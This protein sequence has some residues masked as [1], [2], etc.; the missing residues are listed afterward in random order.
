MRKIAIIFPM[1]LVVS[2]YAQSAVSDIRAYDE[3]VTSKFVT[4]KGYLKTHFLDNKLYLEIP[5]KM[6]DKDMLFVEHHKSSIPQQVKWLKKGNEIR[7]V[8]PEIKS[9]S[10]NTIPLIKSK[11]VRTD[12]YSSYKY[13]DILN[14]KIVPD[15]FPIL[16]MGEEDSSYVIDVTRLF[17]NTPGSLSRR[18]KA[19][20]NGLAFIDKVFAFDNAI[21]V[22]TNKIFAS[23]NGPLEENIDFSL[24]LLPEPMMPRLFDHR[25]G[26]FTETTDL[27]QE[28]V[29]ASIQRWRLEKKHKNKKLSEPVKPIVFYFDPAT[30]DKWKPYIKAGVE[31]WLPAF[32][33]A[34]F[35]GA[36]LI[37]E[38][39][40]N[41][42][43]WSINS[44]RYSYIRWINRSEYREY[45]G[46]GAGSASKVVDQRT[47]E[48]LKGDI[49][50]GRTNTLVNRYFTRCAPLDKRAQQYPFPD[51]LM[52]ELIQSLT[53]HE[54]GHVFGL[55]DGN[56]GIFTYP[57]GK[58]RDKKWLQKM[59]HT[60]SIMSY[61][62][63][64]FVVQPE[65]NI[66]PSLLIQKLGP[67][68]IYSIRW[69]YTQF[70][71]INTPDD[72]LSYL[73]KIVREQDSTPWYKYT[74]HRGTGM[75]GP[76][77]AMEVVGCDNPVKAAELGVKNLQRVIKLIPQA[78]KNQR[79][80]ELLERFYQKTL[81]L[82]V[83][84][85][86]SVVFLVG[87][88]TTRYK[89]AGQEGSIH[90]F[91]AISPSLQKEAIQFLI[92][93][94]F[95]TPS[96]MNSQDISR[97]QEVPPYSFGSI[98]KISNRQIIVLEALLERFRL[99]EE[100]DLLDNRKRYKSADI[101]ND[102]QDGIWSE[103][104]AKKIKIDP[105]RQQV[106]VAYIKRLINC[107]EFDSK[108]IRYRFNN[109][110]RGNILN[111]LKKVEVSIGK[112]LHKVDDASTKA[113]LELCLLELK[114]I[115]I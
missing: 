35:K 41:D 68:D 96:W 10:G 111:A 90:D 79:G 40:V 28:M 46:V 75:A 55:K 3:V 80:T 94:A 78:T 27:D 98:K 13:G 18:G 115:K 87:G 39:P 86:K 109:Y 43:G 82:W 52:G 102:L 37:K 9:K 67:A 97:L 88:Y 5:L 58:M 48:I 91:T 25:M 42:E 50:I 103:L 51:D 57:F 99:F 104:T 26:F 95:A 63:E 84:Q 23:E 1:V 110:T 69:G 36:V 12:I 59:G 24:F 74:Y 66:P 106:Q 71:N 19:I 108:S 30:P 20:H 83:D 62:R 65:D 113:H 70:E 38:P 64:N 7:L 34:G 44:M 16:A 92:K 77:R 14:V 56:Y 73:E 85:M 31:E 54:T 101:L 89:N 61:A 53:A 93:E 112:A 100:V 105:Y 4:K 11:N 32:E 17:L 22:R 45:K 72:E 6:L 47:G 15:T 107:L 81:D 29:R 33:A 21:E 2:G 49:L 60:P 76:D 114:K 8:I